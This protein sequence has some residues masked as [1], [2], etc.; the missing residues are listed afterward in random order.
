ML[1]NSMPD[2]R[3][4]YNLTWF[5]SPLRGN[6]KPETLTDMI[7]VGEWYGKHVKTPA[8]NKKPFRPVVKFRNIDEKVLK[9]VQSGRKSSDSDA[10][11]GEVS[12]SDSEGEEERECQAPTFGRGIPSLN[13]RSVWHYSGRGEVISRLW[14][15]SILVAGLA[16]IIVIYMTTKFSIMNRLYEAMSRRQT[17][18]TQQ[19]IYLARGATR[20]IYTKFA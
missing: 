7:E 1:V 17:P 11:G 18:P 14:F 19:E 10:E 5:N 16:L 8:V 12:E 15:S 2:E 6:Q 20:K 9:S 3:T 13:G 4:N